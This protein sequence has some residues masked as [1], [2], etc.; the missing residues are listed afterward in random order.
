M[1]STDKTWL[2]TD[3]TWRRI[4][5]RKTIK[6]KILNTKSKIIQERLQ[7]GYI[8]KDK[9]IKK[10]ARH[11]KRA[12]VDNIAMRAETAAQKGGIRTIYR[13]T[14]QIYRHTRQV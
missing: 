10:S 1:R 9:V 7:L 6:S 4:E 5:E 8:I 3:K 12:D 13:L 11:D 2:S 14:K